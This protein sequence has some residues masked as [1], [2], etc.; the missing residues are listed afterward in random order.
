MTGR[1]PSL[2]HE[3]CS[4]LSGHTFGN[5][6]FKVRF[7]TWA[8]STLTSM[9]MSATVTCAFHSTHT[10]LVQD[11]HAPS[12]GPVTEFPWRTKLSGGWGG[13]WWANNLQLWTFY[14]WVKILRTDHVSTQHWQILWLPT[15]GVYWRCMHKATRTHRVRC[16]RKAQQR[17]GQPG[18]M[19]AN[20]SWLRLQ[21]VA[22]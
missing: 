12:S 13:C 15:W 22:S 9:W 4:F 14:V 3:G 19:T 8:H 17:E 10:F 16:D 6:S 18:R 7:W 2:E 5:K 21:R 1:S 11:G 20:G